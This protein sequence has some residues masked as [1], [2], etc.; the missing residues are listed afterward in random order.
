M[1]QKEANITP[2][3]RECLDFIAGYLGR[4]GVG[5]NYEEIAG[6]LGLSSKSGAHRMVQ[7]LL[8]QGYLESDKHFNGTLSYRGL[9]IS[10]KPLPDAEIYNLAWA[11]EVCKQAG[12]SVSKENGE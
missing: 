3:Q 7:A 10:R 12:Y 9:R 2:R 8:A 11:I 1:T 4:T 6:A 5:P